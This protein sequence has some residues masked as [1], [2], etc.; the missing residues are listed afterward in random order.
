MSQQINL[1]PP[2]DRSTGQ[3]AIVGGVVLASLCVFGLQWAS[4]AADATELK[5]RLAESERLLT[6]DRAQIV[7][8]QRAQEARGS[9]AS[10]S[11]ELAD[12]RPRADAINQLVN[13]A[14]SGSIGRA[15]GYAD[16]GALLASAAED[17]LWL[18]GVVI[19]KSGTKITVSGRALRN[20]SVVQYA[21]RLNGAFA[22][23]GVQFKSLEI[24]P[25]T[26]APPAAAASGVAAPVQIVQFKL[27]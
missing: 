12:L 10:L 5:R 7:G 3:A 20:E 26:A 8:L 18:T 22:P 9:A 19:E 11:A 13:A 6:G 21:R 1:L 23:L 16:Y 4:V 24:I 15:T 17:G 27:S 2:S 14:R 25:E